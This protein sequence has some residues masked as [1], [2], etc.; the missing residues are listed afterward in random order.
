VSSENRWNLARNF[1]HCNR[2]RAF[3]L[4]PLRPRTVKF[5]DPPA[6]WN[7]QELHEIAP[8]RETPR[9]PSPLGHMMGGVAAGWLFAGRSRR[10]WTPRIGAASWSAT[11]SFAVAGTAPDLDLL[12]GVHSMYTHS[13]GAVAIAAALVLAL[14]RGRERAMAAGVAAAVASHVVLDW[15]GSDTSPPIGV[16]ALWPFSR[17]Y[18]QSPFYVFAAVSRRY[19]LPEFFTGNLLAAV[20][21][22]AILIPIVMAV[23][24]LRA[25]GQTRGH[26][27]RAG[28]ADPGSQE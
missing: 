3:K 4:S 14:T 26:M 18:F 11:W 25:S 23:G 2:L 10:R 1:S 7:G 12:A 9:V 19:W 17:E 16:M 20:R 13:I 27:C 15:L 24:W 22:C 8:A 5:F 21:E 6:G 28:A